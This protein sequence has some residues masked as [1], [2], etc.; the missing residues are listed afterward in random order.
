MK[1][2]AAFD[3]HPHQYSHSSFRT[4]RDYFNGKE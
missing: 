2:P 1:S 4:W 3:T